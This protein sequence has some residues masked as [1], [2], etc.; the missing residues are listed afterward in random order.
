VFQQQVFSMHADDSGNGRESMIDREWVGAAIRQK[1][2]WNE[3]MDRYSRGGQEGTLLV[4]FCF[5]TLL[6]HIGREL[7]NDKWLI[8]REESSGIPQT[9]RE[10]WNNVEL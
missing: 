8:M 3:R 5:S 4:P 1:E 10:F 9:F 2:T 7:I 6:L